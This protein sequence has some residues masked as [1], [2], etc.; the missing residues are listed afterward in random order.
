ML[1]LPIVSLG[2]SFNFKVFSPS[3]VPVSIK[4][5]PSFNSESINIKSAGKVKS[6]LTKTNSP[7]RRSPLIVS[8]H[9]LSL[10]TIVGSLFCCLSN[11]ALE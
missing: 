2:D 6:C 4:H 1:S 3:N 5:I 11:L 8:I 9:L 7:I 10:Y